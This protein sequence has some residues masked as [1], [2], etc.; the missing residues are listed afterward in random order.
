MAHLEPFKIIDGQ[1][2]SLLDEDQLEAKFT[3]AQRSVSG[4]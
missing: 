1:G 4:S 3:F 2:N